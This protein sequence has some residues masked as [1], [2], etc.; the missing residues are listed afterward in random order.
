MNRTELGK[1]LNLSVELIAKGRP[2]RSGRLISPTYVTIHNTSNDGPRADA[3]AHSRFVRNKGYYEWNGK[4]RFVS[5]HYSVDD[6]QIIKQLP[7]NEHA[8]HAGPGNGKSIAIEICMH[9]GIDQGSANA[10]AARLVAALMNDLGIGP[11][12]IVPHKHWTNKTCP[13]LLLPS[14]T[15]FVE[16]AVSILASLTASPTESLA[17]DDVVSVEELALLDQT[18]DALVESAPEDDPDD[19]HKKIANALAEFLA[20]EGD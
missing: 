10:R 20:A 11:D 16:N 8:I 5:W 3:D 4:K 15:T 1:S 12:K 19:E 13:V 9:K 6:K 18:P 14:F 7:I 2:N 17:R